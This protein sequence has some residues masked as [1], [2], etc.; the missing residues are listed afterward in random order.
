MAIYQDSEF[1]KHLVAEFTGILLGIFLALVIV[2]DYRDKSWKKTRILIYD[3]LIYD[4]CLIIEKLCL[5]LS[6]ILE[7]ESIEL[8]PIISDKEKANLVT[9]NTIHNISKIIHKLEARELEVHSSDYL[10]N[11]DTDIKDCTFEI[12]FF[13]TQAL[14]RSSDDDE[15]IKALIDLNNKISN[16]QSATYAYKACSAPTVMPD[17]IS[18]IE[19]LEKLYKLILGKTSCD[20]YQI[21]LDPN[22][23]M[24]LP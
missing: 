17:L 16:F 2:D 13:I 3:S 7:D 15:I 4:L 21:R 6:A 12:K 10:T 19:S 11:F 8:I 22:S 23:V 9:Y 14:V 20:N 24:R 18:L 1:Q 5:N